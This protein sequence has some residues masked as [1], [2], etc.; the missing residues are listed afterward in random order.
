[1][2]VVPGRVVVYNGFVSTVRHLLVFVMCISLLGTTASSV[3]AQQMFGKYF[4]ETGHNVVEETKLLPSPRILT[5]SA[6]FIM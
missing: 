4:T 6:S 2:Y 5:A 1:M 3:Q